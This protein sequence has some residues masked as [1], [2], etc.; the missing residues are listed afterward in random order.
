MNQPESNSKCPKLEGVMGKVIENARTL[1]KSIKDAEEIIQDCE[2][3]GVSPDEYSIVAYKDWLGLAK[4]RFQMMREK[5]QHLFENIPEEVS[6][7]KVQEVDELFG[8]NGIVPEETEEEGGSLPE[9]DD[10]EVEDL[11]NVN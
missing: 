11:L 9:S 2:N 4:T 5:F 8:D 10:E 6:K 1:F 7:L 3:L